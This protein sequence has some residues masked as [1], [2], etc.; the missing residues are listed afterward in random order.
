MATP[1]ANAAD[2]IKSLLWEFLLD[3]GRVKKKWVEQV[4]ELSEK[5]LEQMQGNNCFTPTELSQVRA[6]GKT[7]EEKGFNLL[8]LVQNGNEKAKIDFACAL[9]IMRR[10]LLDLIHPDMGNLVLEAAA[11]EYV[12]IGGIAI[13]RAAFAERLK[14]NLA[15]AK[16]KNIVILQI[17]RSGVGKSTLV[18]SLIADSN[19]SNKAKES[20]G[21][22]PG[23]KL[24]ECYSIPLITDLPCKIVV[25]LWDTPG[26][27]DTETADDSKASEGRT[28][29]YLK[30]IA[31]KVEKV[32][33]I[34]FCLDCTNP[35][36]SRQD[37]MIIKVL[38]KIFGVNVWK[39]TLMVLTKANMLRSTSSNDDAKA[40][41]RA[42]ETFQSEFRVVVEKHGREKLAKDIMVVAAGSDRDRMLAD[43]K[44]W[45]PEFWAAAIDS[46]SSD[47]ANA[48]LWDLG[49]RLE[50]G[51]L[52]LSGI[53]GS[54]IKKIASS[55]A[56]SSRGSAGLVVNIAYIGGAVGAAAAAGA[57]IGVPFG[58]PLGAA[59][60]S[61]IGAGV[62]L[63]GGL[64]SWHAK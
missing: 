14:L 22:R 58:G 46:S 5:I 41:E 24:P 63:L 4:G 8:K 18:N 3:E 9:Y 48:L 21:M 47:C 28:H 36:L 62:G 37:V 61:S 60:G 16:D 44:P 32:D 27:F 20:G 42:R 40:L 10:E 52:D 11:R 64:I 59:I 31:R 25:N 23:T 57:I 33:L 50:N 54:Q 26:L 53:T 29:D 1:T 38:G 51:E 49:K 17:G 43:G 15:E 56:K 12:K 6:R 34:L 55:A 35:R 13:R 2:R 39:S 30:E 45:L 7:N 19:C